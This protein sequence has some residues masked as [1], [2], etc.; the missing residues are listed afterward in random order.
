[1]KSRP[2]A[3]AISGITKV[4]RARK[5]APDGI[6][7]RQRSRARANSTPIG[8]VIAV[9]ST[10]S[11]RVWVSALRRDSSFSTEPVG[12]QVYQRS[13]KPCHAPRERPALKEK[14]TVMAT[15]TSD[16]SR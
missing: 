12:S 15:G 2:M 6:R 5:F 13:E 1:M 10:A 7:P 9:V 16:H 3:R 8:T 14:S 4:M 11:S